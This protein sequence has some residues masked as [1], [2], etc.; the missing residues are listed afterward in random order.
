MPRA[1]WGRSTSPELV[2]NAFTSKASFDTPELK[3]VVATA[4]RFMDNVVDAGR[5]PLAAQRDKAQADRQLGLGVTGLADA[6]LMLGVRYGSPEAVEWTEKIMKELTLAA[7]RTS[8]Q[9]AEEKGAFPNFDADEFLSPKRFAGRMLPET[10]QADIRRHGIRNALLV[11][12]APT[13]TISLFAGNVSSGIEP[14]FAYSY[15]RKVLE[16]DGKTKREERVVDYAVAIWESAYGVQEKKPEWFVTTDELTPKEHV[17]MMAAAQKWVDSSISKTVNLPEDISFEDFKAV[18]RLAYNSGCKGCTTYRPNDVTGSVLTSDD[19]PKEPEYSSGPAPV[20]ITGTAKVTGID[21]RRDITDEELAQA[22]RDYLHTGSGVTRELSKGKAKALLAEL[23]KER[24]MDVQDTDDRY[25]LMNLFDPL[26]DDSDFIEAFHRGLGEAMDL[27]EG[28]TGLADPT[29]ANQMILNLDEKQARHIAKSLEGLGRREGAGFVSI[30]K[31]MQDQIDNVAGIRED[32]LAKPEP[33]EKV[34]DGKTYK[35]KMPNSPH[36][37][38]VTV[39]DLGGRPYEVFIASKDVSHFAWTTALTRMVSAVFR[40]G[41]DV[42]F[43]VEELKAIFDPAGGA[44]VEGSFIPS[45]PAAIGGVIGD[46]M[47]A[48]GYTVGGKLAEKPRR[49]YPDLDL[50]G[51][52]TRQ[53]QIAQERAKTAATERP[54]WST[55]GLMTTYGGGERSSEAERPVLGAFQQVGKP[56]PMLCPSCF[57]TNLRV[58]SGCLACLDCGNSKCG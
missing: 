26:K 44:W 9:L 46:H 28:V 14:V 38:Y 32:L 4:I 33:R 6:L 53:A 30:G 58:E 50:S 51:M 12:I 35:I 47:E 25:R 31:F 15:T 27:A 8:I 3:R 45:V 11:S 54:N 23:G 13:G 37:I 1:C 56:G 24:V 57:S 19:K 43:V 49:E 52:T 42:S 48:I 36:A 18:Y 10:M 21:P 34:L 16:K 41:G 55:E 39:N 20:P 29:D 7:Y 22:A 2:A 5:F 17:A 40:R